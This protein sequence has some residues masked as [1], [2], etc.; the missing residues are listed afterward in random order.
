MKFYF[1]YNKK[2]LPNY[3]NGMFDDTYPPIDYITTRQGEVP[4]VARGRSSAAN[5][6][7]RYSLPKEM[8]NTHDLILEKLST[9]SFN[10]FTNYAKQYYISQYNP[11]CTV[12]NCYICN[13]DES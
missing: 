8:S 7:L 5:Q 4:V 13:R 11:L 12:A 6:S 3:F 9:H 10:G 1:K 2:S